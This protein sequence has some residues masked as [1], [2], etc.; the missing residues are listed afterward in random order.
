MQLDAELS[1]MGAAIINPLSR[2]A[3]KCTLVGS[4]ALEEGPRGRSIWSLLGELRV[5][6]PGKHSE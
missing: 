3:S 2:W 4:P 5:G 6:G 1:W